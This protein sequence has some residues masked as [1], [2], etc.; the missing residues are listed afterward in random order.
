MRTLMGAKSNLVSFDVLFWMNLL[1]VIGASLDFNVSSPPKSDLLTLGASDSTSN[2]SFGHIF[3]VN[4]TSL[5]SGYTD[6]IPT[7]TPFPYKRLAGIGGRNSKW[8]SVYHQMNA[9]T[10]MEDIWHVDNGVWTSTA[11]T[12]ETD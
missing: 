6:I 2:S 1:T 7:T 9:T 8:C 5:S 11:I 12:V 4:G 3:W 10:L